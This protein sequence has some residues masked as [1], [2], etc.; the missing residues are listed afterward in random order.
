MIKK[1]R[2]IM[3]FYIETADYKEINIVKIQYFNLKS[4]QFNMNIY[5]KMIKDKE[6]LEEIKKI[7]K[8]YRY[9]IEFF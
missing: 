4:I 7:S 8:E 3:Q 2:R 9:K 5:E 1:T 6:T